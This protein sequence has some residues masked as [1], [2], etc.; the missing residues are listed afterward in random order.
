MLSIARPLLRLSP[1]EVTF[2][3]RRFHDPG[4]ELRL[5]LEGVGQAFRAGY[6]AALGQ[7]EP[8]PLG[9]RLAEIPAAMR[10]FAYEGAGMA[11]ALQD[12]LSI[13]RRDR[14]ERF[15]AGPGDPHVFLVIIGAGWVLA[16]LPL[17]VERLLARFDPLFRWLALD[18]YG[19]HEGYF[20]W[21]RSV[22]ERRTP[23]KLSGYA[24]H[25]FDQGLGRSLWF[26][27]G[28]EVDRIA[29]AIRGFA[30][31]RQTDLWSGV[32]LACA[33]AGGRSA[34]EMR[35]LAAHA[36]E[37]DH[38]LGQGAAFAAVA[39]QRAGNQ[40]LH[41]ELACQVLCGLSAAAAAALSD[42][43]RAGLPPDDPA[44]DG[45]PAFEIWRRRIRQRL[46]NMQE[47]VAS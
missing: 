21:P 15:L 3:K 38:A 26:V 22:V 12:A 17:S 45:V 36:G 43:V 19:F 7:D 2:A 18:G 33:Y 44:P 14:V 24:R 29:A 6:H 31:E 23:A 16:R 27:C 13:R 39:R 37:H 47:E 11:L 25:G 30:T 34:E 35:R 10:G 40:A 8:E 9:A 41:T 4:P 28:G 42:E 5:R 1:D 46:E 32:G 20:R